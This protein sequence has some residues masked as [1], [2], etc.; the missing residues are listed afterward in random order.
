ML[1]NKLVRDKIPEYIQNKGEK[2]LFHIASEQ[3]YQIKLK[4]KLAE[5]VK[6]FLQNESIEEL[7]DLLEVIDAIVEYKGFDK[8]EL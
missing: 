4:E 7:V 5:E 8:N 6:E 1:Y 3:E 2:V